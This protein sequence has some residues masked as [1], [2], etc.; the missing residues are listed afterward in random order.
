MPDPVPGL[1]VVRSSDIYESIYA[2]MQH[3][4]AS[5]MAT[6]AKDRAR[7]HLIDPRAVE[8]IL[9]GLSLLKPEDQVIVLSRILADERNTPR[10]HVGFGGEVPFLNIRGALIAARYRR[11]FTKELATDL[12]LGMETV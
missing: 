2:E 10:R 1:N 6:R 7:R 11:R 5:R 3:R 9:R 4:A 12:P 8:S